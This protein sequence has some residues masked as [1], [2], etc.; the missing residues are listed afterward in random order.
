MSADPTSTAGPTSGPRLVL[1][2]VGRLLGYGLLGLVGLL[3]ILL[4]GGA[5]YESIASRQAAALPG[6]GSARRCGRPSAAP[7]LL[8]A[9]QPHGGP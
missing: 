6:S 2:R 4:A 5:T 7:S 9:G 8:W 1:R 3:L